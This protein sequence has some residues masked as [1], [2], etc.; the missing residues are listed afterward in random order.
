MDFSDAWDLSDVEKNVTKAAVVRPYS[1]DQQIEILSI[2]W[3]ICMNNTDSL[4]NIIVH[5][6]MT[7]CILLLYFILC[8][9]GLDIL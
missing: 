1:S 8:G 6:S 3:G 5:M 4:F 9:I 7:Y 2:F